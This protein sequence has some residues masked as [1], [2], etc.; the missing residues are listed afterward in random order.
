M[1]ASWEDAV[2]TECEKF[3]GVH[4][5]AA[6]P[7]PRGQVAGPWPNPRLRIGWH[8]APSPVALPARHPDALHLFE[9]RICVQ[10]MSSN[11]KPV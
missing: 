4:P 2:N 5:P 6:G 11:F 7:E 1:L 10:T 3:L 9:A 8:P